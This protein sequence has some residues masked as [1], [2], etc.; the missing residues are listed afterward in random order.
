[1][2]TIMA[3]TRKI[4][5]DNLG[6]TVA[7]SYIGLFG[8]IFYD[9]TTGALR[10]SDGTTPGGTLLASGGGGTSTKIQNGTSKAEIATSN[11]DTVITV[12]SRTWTFDTTGNVTI[13][14]YIYGLG[15]IRIDNSTTGTNADIDLYSA[16]NIRL[17]GKDQ[18]PGEER[19]GGDISIQGGSGAGGPD[20]TGGDISVVSGSG[21]NAT[22]T[23]AGGDG[24]FT[25]IGCRSGGEANTTGSQNAGNG[26]QLQLYAGSGGFNDGNPTLGGTGGDVN[27]R[28]GTS[29]RVG[30]GGNVNI[31]AG[32]DDADTPGNIVFGAGRSKELAYKELYAAL[33]FTPVTLSV[34]GTPSV[35]GAGARAFINNSNA[36]ASGNFGAIAE[37]G[38]SNIVPVYSDGTNWRIG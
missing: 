23:T 10:L 17:Q 14:G 15:T 31:G 32:V 33:L 34:L 11:G 9:D 37:D 18:A 27:I 2:A 8:E 7:T 28:G 12:D 24:G 6:A 29:T 5:T 30:G 3:T 35:V 13:P 1:M 20:G 4:F 22:E 21:G 38:G 16:D 26:S 25:T 36:V 19:E